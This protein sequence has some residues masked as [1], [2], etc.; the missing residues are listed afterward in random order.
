MEKETKKIEYEHQLAVRRILLE[1]ILLASVVTVLALLGNIWLQHNDNKLTHNRFL[2]ENRLTGILEVR[3]AYNMLT[4]AFL[5]YAE[6]SLRIDKK[7]GTKKISA[8]DAMD[9]AIEQFIDATNK[10]G[11]VHPIDFTKKVGGHIT[12][13]ACLIQCKIT[14]NRHTVEFLS[15]IDV[16]FD[17][18]TRIAMHGSSGE[19]VPKLG[20]D[21]FELEHWEDRDIQNL[22]TARYF[23][24]NFTRWEKF[25]EIK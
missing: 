10:W 3:H 1:K 18:H 25:K 11:I 5:K 22:G 15:D 13:Y 2:T 7:D 19:D 9:R 6:A 14:I 8:M 12:L 21:V 17:Y 24:A 4:S 23:L 20:V 16:N